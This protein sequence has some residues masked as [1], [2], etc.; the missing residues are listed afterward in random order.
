MS[1][2][3]ADNGCTYQAVADAAQ[4]PDGKMMRV[5][6][7]GRRI[8]IAKVDGE[9]YAVDDNCSHEDVSLYLG[10]LEGHNI[11]C[12]LHGS[13]FDL[14]SGQPMEE[15]ADE[16]IATWPVRVRDGRIEVAA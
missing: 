16:P 14:R 12:S 5:D 10:C 15:P 8:L 2:D 7:N 6:V 4:L 9:L 13:R 11:R 3:V 1:S